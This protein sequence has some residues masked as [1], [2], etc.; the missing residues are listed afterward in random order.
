MGAKPACRTSAA[1]LTGAIFGFSTIVVWRTTFHLNFGFSLALF[2][3]APYFAMRYSRTWALRDAAGAGAVVGL[4]IMSDLTIALF[5]V[6]AIAAYVVIAAI[7]EGVLK[8]WVSGAGVMVAAALIVG[9]PQLVMVAR[10]ATNDGYDP[11]FESLAASWTGANTNLFTMLSPGNVRDAV[12]GTLET[13]AYRYPWGEATPTYGWG[14]LG[15]ALACLLV[16]GLRR[17]ASPIPRRFLIWATLLLVG[18]TLLALGPELTFTDTP[19]VPLAEERYGQRLSLLMPY[20][21]LTHL[22]LFGDV[23]MPSR[24]TMMGML[25]LALLA[26]AGASLL[27]RAGRTGRAV[28]AVLVAFAVLESGFPD[29][30]V[31]QKWVPIERSSLYEPIQ[32]DSGDSVVVDVPLGFLGATAGA[33]EGAAHLEPMLRAIQHGH[34][35]AEGYMTR[36][37]QRQVDALVGRPFYSSVLALQRKPPGEPA[38]P[39]VDRAAA[40]ADLRAIGVGWVVV[41]PEAHRRVIPFLAQLG[42]V[43]EREEDGIIVM[44]HR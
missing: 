28:L 8:S 24:F 30:G 14:A 27:W 5:G 42:F 37:T 16:L 9:A 15:L 40:E 41:W 6:L 23:R 39:A 10:A 2:P 29:G 25:G 26:G 38:P 22:P 21:W 20:T 1:W 43:R 3:L 18:G 11:N 13:L 4:L 12:P 19:H 17:A 36:L 44:R 32:A 35:M 34:P 33:G 31:G 7:D